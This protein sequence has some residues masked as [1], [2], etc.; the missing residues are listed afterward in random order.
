M[1]GI[2]FEKGYM[3]VFSVMLLMNLAAKYTSHMPLDVDN[4][5][6]GSELW[7]GA[8]EAYVICFI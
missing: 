7:F 1:D 8:S 6:P 3:W 5:L 2:L 4:G